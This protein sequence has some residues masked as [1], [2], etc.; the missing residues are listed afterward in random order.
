MY[1]DSPIQLVF[2]WN[3]MHTLVTNMKQRAKQIQRFPKFDGTQCWSWNWNQGE[4][5]Y[6]IKPKQIRF[7]VSP[8]LMV[9]VSHP[10][11]FV[12]VFRHFV[13]K[14]TPRN[15]SKSEF[16][17]MGELTYQETPLSST[18]HWFEAHWKFCITVGGVAAAVSVFVNST[19]TT[20]TET[21]MLSS[22]KGPQ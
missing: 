6:E 19:S 17:C 7:N 14:K 12:D 1:W 21:A 13:K 3:V 18:Y 20:N 8:N 10:L 2:C 22:Q 5:K 4:K 16:R 9:W 11:R 15:P